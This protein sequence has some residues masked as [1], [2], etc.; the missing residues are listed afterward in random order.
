[1]RSARMDAGLVA[2]S[3]DSGGSAA[4]L[5]AANHVA[6]NGSALSHTI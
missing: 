3:E 1:M 5:P 6:L 2:V 4:Y